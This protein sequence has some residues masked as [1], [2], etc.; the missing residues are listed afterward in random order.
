VILRGGASKSRL[1]FSFDYGLRNIHAPFRPF[2][3][4][5]PH[6]YCV[7]QLTIFIIMSN[8][9]QLAAP[10]RYRSMQHT[11]AFAGLAGKTLAR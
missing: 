1:L 10:A 3:L 5:N 6:G 2:S 7:E 8:A 11:H 4:H 9:Q